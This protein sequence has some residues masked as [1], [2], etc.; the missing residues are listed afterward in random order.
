MIHG[1]FRIEA[2][3]PVGHLAADSESAQ[4]FM[5]WACV[6]PEKWKEYKPTYSWS[7]YHARRFKEPMPLAD[8]GITRAPQ[9]WQYLTEGQYAKLERR[10]I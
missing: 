8:L 5:A 4:D 7:I 10:A 6:T 9:S 3:Q 2:Y 1:Y